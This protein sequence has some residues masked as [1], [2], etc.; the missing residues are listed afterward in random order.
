[1]SLVYFQGHEFKGQGRRQHFPKMNFSDGG[2]P[3][4][5][6]SLMKTISQVRYDCSFKRSHS[7]ESD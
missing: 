2:T 1:M 4:D 6:G 7:D 3:I 5:V